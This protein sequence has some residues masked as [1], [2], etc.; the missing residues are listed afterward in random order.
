MG[1]TKQTSNPNKSSS[2]Y[3]AVVVGGG[4]A[5][6]AAA[7]LLAQRG[8]QVTI[9]ERNETIGG[10]WQPYINQHGERFTQGVRIPETTGIDA[11]DDALFGD[12]V[13]GDWHVFSTLLKEG[14]TFNGITDDICG[15]IDTTQLDQSTYQQGF[16]ELLAA[17]GPIGQKGPCQPYSN[18]KQQLDA[19][20][21]ETFTE[22]IYR[23]LMRKYVGRELEDLAPHTH[24]T[25]IPQ[26]L[27]IGNADLA[28]K[29]HHCPQYGAT[30]AHE[31]WIDLGDRY[32][33]RF[34]Y[35]TQGDSPTWV[36]YMINKATQLGV[37]FS[38]SS[39]VATVHHANKKATGVTLH[40]GQRINCDTLVWTIPSVFLA[41]AADLPYVG[42]PPAMRDLHLTYLTLNEPANTDMFYLTDF[43]ADHAMFRATFLNNLAEGLKVDGPQR[44]VIETFTSASERDDHEYIAKLVTDEL[45]H[46][47]VIAGDHAGIKHMESSVIQ[48]IRPVY[49]P[50]Q[51]TET[52]YSTSVLGNQ[53][54]NVIF[55]GRSSTTC[56]LAP[57]VFIEVYNAINQRFG[58][59]PQLKQVA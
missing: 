14:H 37:K 43:D 10:L 44:V 30:I 23:P 18:Q 59:A 6:I 49:T 22:T 8:Q 55:G 17:S 57:H 16:S 47:G 54:N 39:Q 52:A 48:N 29:L 7:I 53:L 3:S 50:A 9:I 51:L 28:S 35:P 1:K 56:Y 2:H 11:L 58:D 38:T 27:K 34:I 5:G 40:N 36:D 25:L 31:S 42:S 19:I 45:I 24:R 46:T 12:V 20:Y 33:G 41:N 26:R 15:C 4:L 13:N 32:K 21:G